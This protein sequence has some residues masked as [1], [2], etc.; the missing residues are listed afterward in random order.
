VTALTLTAFRNYSRLRLALDGRPVVLAGPNGA[1][2]TNL[3]E[4]VSYLGTGRGL[5][6]ARLADVDARLGAA[7]AH[8]WAVAAALSGPFG[9]FEVGTGRDGEAAVSRRVVR[10]DGKPQSGPAALADR[11]PLLWL[12]PAQDRIFLDQPGA[13]R[14]FLDRLVAVL[15]PAHAA[16]VNEYERALRER[17]RLLKEPGADAAWVGALERTMAETGIAVAAA[18]LLAVE[19]LSRAAKDGI[20]PF[21]AAHLAAVGEAE[22]WLAGGPALDAEDRLAE[23][24]AG[25]RARDAEAGGAAHG[26]HRTDLVVSDA[27]RGL[28]AANMSTGE[29]K[30]LLLSI[31]L[32]AARIQAEKH[33]F[34]PL[35]LLDEVSAHLD[36]A[37]RRALYAEV[38]AL[39]AQAWMTG[40]DAGLFAGLEGRAQV[41][42]VSDGKVE[43]TAR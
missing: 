14:R 34:A 35:L 43:E 15:D 36:E 19:D 1:G 38:A 37:H 22:E 41:F 5:R 7:E 33:G 20:G 29:Q 30:S 40:T 13:R 8:P 11:V 17:A 27:A 9:P 10:L 12:T 16:R 21:P 28:A 2:K 25:S 42:A 24:L 32:A 31:V 3:L 39:G 6:G 26:P 18:R 23:A 4:A